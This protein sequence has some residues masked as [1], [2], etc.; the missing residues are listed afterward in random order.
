MTTA[1]S[2]GRIGGTTRGTGSSGAEGLVS[3]NVRMSVFT[4]ITAI[5][6]LGFTTWLQKDLHLASLTDPDR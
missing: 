1:S 3:S 4:L 2:S 5:V 6:T